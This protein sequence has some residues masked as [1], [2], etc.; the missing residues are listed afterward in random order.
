MFKLSQFGFVSLFGS[1]L[2][3]LFQ[4]ISSVTNNDVIS[5]KLKLVDILEPSFFDWAE[6]IT[7]FQFNHFLNFVL[8]QQLFILLLFI[9]GFFFILSGILDKKWI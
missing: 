1:M 2:V 9:A 4:V 5:K 7:L 6:G 8:N 3:L